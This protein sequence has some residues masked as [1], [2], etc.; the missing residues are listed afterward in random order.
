MS[1]LSRFLAVR[2]EHE[3]ALAEIRA[4]R[5]R[6][7]WMWFVFPQAAGLGFSPTSRRYAIADADEAVAYLDDPDLRADYVEMVDAVCE[8]VIEHGVSVHDLFGAP[9]DA[10]LVSS[11]TLFSEVARVRFPDLADMV[12]QADA[13]LDAA[14]RQGL[15]RCDV[16]RRF[17]GEP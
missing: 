16:T 13:I 10:K 15:R 12:V 8:Q 7:H 6:S 9:D 14:T 11:L 4:G 17:L 5:K 1:D 3:G 2:S